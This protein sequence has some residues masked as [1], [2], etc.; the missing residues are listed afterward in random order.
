[1]EGK[2]PGTIKTEY[3]IDLP[4]P[5]EHARM[6]LLKRCPFI[7]DNTALIL[8]YGKRHFSL[9]VG[10]LCAGL[11]WRITQDLVGRPGGSVPG[12]RRPDGRWIIRAPRAHRMIQG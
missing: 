7:T 9:L 10:C 4:R 8:Y 6:E 3:Q 11:I 2:L 1:M 5:R 12:R